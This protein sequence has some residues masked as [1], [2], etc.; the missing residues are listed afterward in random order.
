MILLGLGMIMDNNALKC[1]G[2][3]PKLTQI[4]AMLMILLKHLSSLTTCL[5]CFHEIL[6][7]SGADKLL[8]L[9]IAIINSFLKKEFYSECYLVRRS[10]NKDSLTCQLWA[11]LNVR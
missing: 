3:C 7:G 8:H 6:S 11:E 9:S 10:S 4:L 2:Q 5:R 1:D